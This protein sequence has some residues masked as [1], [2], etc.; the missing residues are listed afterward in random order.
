MSRGRGGGLDVAE[1][2]EGGRGFRRTGERMLTLG[3]C[4][5]KVEKEGI[6]MADGIEGFRR[7]GGRVEIVG[8]PA[9][10]PADFEFCPW[11]MIHDQSFTFYCGAPSRTQVVVIC[12]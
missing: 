5:W 12:G 9:P 11:S 8:R 4:A 7:G 10:A 6:S 2:A 3:V 1:A